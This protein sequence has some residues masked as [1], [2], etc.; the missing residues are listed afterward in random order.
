M[1]WLRSLQAMVM[2]VAGGY[3]TSGAMLFASSPAVPDYSVDNSMSTLARFPMIWTCVQALASDI[4]GLPLVAVR[5]L[6]RPDHDASSGILD[7]QRSW[8]EGNREQRRAAIAQHRRELRLRLVGQVHQRAGLDRAIVH[9]PVLEL[10]YQ[11][12]AGSDG[13]LFRKQ[14]A[15]DFILCGNAYLWAPE[16]P[17][18]QAIY[19]LHPGSVRPI[20]GFLGVPAGYEVDD[21]ISG[22]TRTY[23]PNQI[24]HVRDVSWQN[25]IVSILGESAVRCLHDDLTAD[26]NIRTTISKASTR[27]RPDILF[28]TKAPLGKGVIEKLET[29][30][31]ETGLKRNGAFMVGDDV[32]ATVLSW[33]PQEFNDGPRQE[34]LRTTILAVFGVPPTRAGLTT[35]SYGGARQESRVYWENLRTRW[36]VPFEC[37][38]SR[39]AGS[40]VRVEHDYSSV[41]ALQ[42]SY[43]ERLMRV[44]T[45]VGLGADPLEAARYEG[46]DD[47]PLASGLDPKAA[48]P[49][50]PIDRQ[51]TEPQT[52]GGKIAAALEL[53]LRCAEVAYEEVQDGAVDRSL[54][55]R[56]QSERLFHTLTDAGLVTRAA[57]PHA[58]ARWWAE[59][60][61]GIVDELARAG[62][63]GTFGREFA[64]RQATR[65]VE[66]LRTQ[67]VEE[68]A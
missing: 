1:R 29:R 51:P 62:A 19:R 15:V 66:W 2:R 64:E 21:E 10:L 17:A 68:A 3:L 65:I 11:P 13:W 46:F 47:A 26:L 57:E 58:G 12:N 54:F 40:G 24:G 53:H 5:S 31:Q 30:W 49:A 35:A 63:E 18:S 25:T 36:C 43:T 7:G 38:F 59:E 50:K 9:D 60:L 33:T 34:G 8:F 14:L 44:S 23:P 67:P 56:W 39:L 28:S 55:V 48:K 16:G 20:P 61:S 37:A 4:A 42:V 52:V 41:E 27:G 22:E 32:T 6:P 45:W